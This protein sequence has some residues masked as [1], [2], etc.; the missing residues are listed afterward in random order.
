MTISFQNAFNHFFPERV[1]FFLPRTRL[2][3]SL[4]KAFTFFFLVSD[5]Y[6]NTHIF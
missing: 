2:I 6:K 1:K 4:K 3:I 5:R